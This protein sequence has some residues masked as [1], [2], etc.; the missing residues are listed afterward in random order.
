MWLSLGGMI[1]YLFSSSLFTFSI[2]LTMNTLFLK[3]EKKKGSK[4]YTFLNY[5]CAS[6]GKFRTLDMALK[7][8]PSLVPS[9]VSAALVNGSPFLPPS[10]CSFLHLQLQPPPSSLP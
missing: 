3:S 7:V 9:S 10:P 4:F 5:Y 6:D 2:F 8:P 1:I